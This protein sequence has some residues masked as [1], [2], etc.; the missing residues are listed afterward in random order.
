MGEKDAA[1]HVFNGKHNGCIS[2]LPGVTLIGRKQA[3]HRKSSAARKRLGQALM[4]PRSTI[5]VVAAATA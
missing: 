3:W 5:H 1:I 4:G 2:H